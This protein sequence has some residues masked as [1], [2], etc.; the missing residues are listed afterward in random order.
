MADLEK[1]L[2]PGTKVI[3]QCPVYEAG[4][5]KR[6]LAENL[7][8]LGL[9]VGLCGDCHGYDPNCNLFAN[10]YDNQKL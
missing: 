5:E 6:H 8:A 10:W 7:R 9:N 1:R 4:D 3:P 2:E